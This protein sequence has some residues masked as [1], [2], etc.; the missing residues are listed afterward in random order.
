MVSLKLA[1]TLAQN[2]LRSSELHPLLTSTAATPLSPSLWIAHVLSSS[3]TALVTTPL[4]GWCSPATG[5]LPAPAT[6]LLLGVSAFI[7]CPEGAYR[8]LS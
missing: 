1:P 3:G 5:L 6:E 4:R 2:R 8:P 7:D